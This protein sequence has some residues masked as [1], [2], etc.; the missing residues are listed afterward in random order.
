MTPAQP[1]DLYRFDTAEAVRAWRAIDDRVMGGVSRSGLRHDPAG[2]AT[3]EGEVSLEQNGGFASVRSAPS[4]L[5][6]SGALD[7]V[8]E[9]R[10]D[11]KRY[12]LCLFVVDAF[13]ALSYQAEF[14]PAAHA[15][16]VISLPIAAFTATTRGRRVA[17]A[18]ALDPARIR[19]VGLMI[20]GRQAGRF[21]LDI[22]SIRLG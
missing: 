7:C 1:G 17:D 21:A 2:H 16:D 10:G 15:W 6:V 14:V 5:G 4:P 20:S 19:Q 13:D 3:F 8:I 9:A 11:G 12:K 18:P 22:R